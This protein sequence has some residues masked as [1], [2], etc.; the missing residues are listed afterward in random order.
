MNWH[1]I[2]EFIQGI[3]SD[4]YRFMGAQPAENGFR[5]AVWAP[6]AAEVSVVGDFNNWKVRKNH[7]SSLGQCGIWVG[8]VENATEG[9]CYKFAIRHRDN[10]VFHYKFDPF[11]SLH[12]HP[13]DSAS[14]LYR[15]QFHWNDESWIVKRRMTEPR[16]APISIYELHLGSWRNT[17]AKSS[18]YREIGPHLIEYIK[19]CGFTHV[20]FL[21]LM[22]HPFYGS[23]GYQALGYF[24][25]SAYYGEPDD[26]RYLI[27]LL[28]Q[29]NIGVIMDWVPAHFPM[30]GHGLFQYDGSYQF[31]YKNP[32]KGYH[33][34]W[35]TAVFDYSSPQVQSF[36]VSS[37]RYWIEEFHVDGLRVDAVASM[38]YL[39][40]ARSHGQW[41]PN[42]WGG[43]ENIEAVAFVKKLNYMISQTFPG[44][45]TFAEESTT[46]P[47]VTGPVPHGGLGF[48]FK[49]DMGWMNDSL[50]YIRR[51]PLFRKFHHTDLTFRGVYAHNEKY[52][53]ALSHDEVVHGKRSL[54]LK[55][56]G[57][58]WKRF[59]SIRA[60][61]G[62]QFGQPGKKLIFMGMEFGQLREWSHERYLDWELLNLAGHHGMRS[63]FRALNQLYLSCPPLYELDYQSHGV[64]WSSMDDVNNSTI[65]FIRVSSDGD[66]IL[67]C[68]NFTPQVLY[69]YR[70]GV[71]K[72]GKWIEVFNSDAKEYGGSGVG[73]E[74][75]VF[76]Q[77]QPHHRQPYSIQIVVPPLAAV[78]LRFTP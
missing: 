7:L 48:T 40:Y 37:A 29:N 63:C 53:L 71:P 25:P 54:P 47:H 68:C 11:G 61:W 1:K 34:E 69:N 19:F 28:H 78:Y 31:E 39:N 38:L 9:D 49:W 36:L 35:K 67:V 6:N 73:V 57:D 42:P 66:M 72:M 45:M 21:P 44:V 50:K 52:I 20:E 55:A 8:E 58:E 26:L 32:Q 76:A 14:V 5:F 51:D 22:H 23:W 13:P 3:S 24:A 2:T 17:G 59:A 60:L 75:P 74:N 62:L 65:G 4:A 16:S 77:E 10:S 46:W 30:D 18:L 27:D 56:S 15:S 41:S 12:Q 70:L 33:P 64:I 43:N